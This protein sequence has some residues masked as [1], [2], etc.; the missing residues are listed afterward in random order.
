ML[1]KSDSLSKSL[2]I[3]SA[4]HIFMTT[5]FCWDKFFHRNGQEFITNSL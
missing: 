5:V 2:Q 1:W 3:K 4:H